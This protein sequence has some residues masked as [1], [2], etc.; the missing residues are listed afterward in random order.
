MRQGFVLVLAWMLLI[1]YS[2]ADTT[3]YGRVRVHQAYVDTDGEDA[4]WSLEQ[5]SSRLGFRGSEDLGNGL[6]AVYHYE[7]GVDV[8]DGVTIGGQENRLA[9]AGLRSDRY[10][11]LLLGTQDNPYYLAV[12]KKFDDQFDAFNDGGYFRMEG[13]SRSAN[14]ITYAMP[15]LFGGLTLSG[16]IVTDGQ[17]ENENLDSWQLAAIWENEG[18]LFAGISYRE[19][20]EG[21]LT[22]VRPRISDPSDDFK[23]AGASLGYAFGAL[24]VWANIQVQNNAADNNQWGG[25]IFPFYDFGNNRIYGEYYYQ[26]SSEDGDDDGFRGFILGYHHKFSKRTRIYTEY[27]SFNADRNLEQEDPDQKQFAV[28]IRHD[29]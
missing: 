1:P 18:G 2:H 5:K 28:G 17:N 21:A 12:G 11:T 27:E 16:A 10:G 6:S 15:S 29:F 3:V 23:Q 26:A 4:Y 14:M 20:A 9:Y 8:A 25:E 19:V 24:Q 13:P 7:F 22:T